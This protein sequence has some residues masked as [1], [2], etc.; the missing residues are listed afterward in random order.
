[1][2]GVERLR[3]VDASVMPVVPRGSTNAPTISHRRAGGGLI[4]GRA[5]RSRPTDRPSREPLPAELG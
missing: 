2:R 4:I 1:M 3:V 5:P